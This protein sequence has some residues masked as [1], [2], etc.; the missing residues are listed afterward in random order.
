MKVFLFEVWRG[1]YKRDSYVSREIEGTGK[2]EKDFNH[3]IHYPPF[4]ISEENI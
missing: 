3:F 1:G 4:W 2:R